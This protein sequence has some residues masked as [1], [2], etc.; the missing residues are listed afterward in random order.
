[1]AS[2]TS[3]AHS[4]TGI[5]RAWVEAPTPPPGA[6]SFQVKS[7]ALDLTVRVSVVKGEFAIAKGSHRSEQN[8][9]VY[10]PHHSSTFRKILTSQEYGGQAEFLEAVLCKMARKAVKRVKFYEYYK[11]PTRELLTSLKQLGADLNF[12]K[13]IE[14]TSEL[15]ANSLKNTPTK[16]SLL[17][18]RQVLPRDRSNSGSAQDSQSSSSQSSQPGDIG[19]PLSRVNSG[20]K[21][22]IPIRALSNERLGEALAAVAKGQGDPM[23]LT[24]MV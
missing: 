2:I 24:K 20:E 11:E 15:L 13:L 5:S 12:P 18:G 7:N 19:S 8:I 21:K 16:P 3:A 17:E 1:M 4:L 14:Q 10:P 9:K 23:D 22:S 6:L